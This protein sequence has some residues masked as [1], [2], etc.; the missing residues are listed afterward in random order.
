MVSIKLVS[1]PATLATHHCSHNR[2]SN[3][4]DKMV[5][6][7]KEQRER[8]RQWRMEKVERGKQTTSSKN[9]E[10]KEDDELWNAHST[11]TMMTKWSTLKILYDDFH[12]ILFFSV[13]ANVQMDCSIYLYAST[14]LSSVVVHIFLVAGFVWKWLAAQTLLSVGWTIS[15][16]LFCCWE[17]HRSRSRNWKIWANV[18]RAIFQKLFS[19][20]LQHVQLHSSSSISST[21]SV[22]GSTMAHITWLGPESTTCALCLCR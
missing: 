12:F 11:W 2:T 8:E 18:E 14:K 7:S 19:F 13:L 20:A 9:E 5:N 6:M 17:R 16:H 1:Q 21:F 10:P 22:D 15:P 4:C 3:R